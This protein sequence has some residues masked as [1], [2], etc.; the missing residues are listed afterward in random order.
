MKKWSLVLAATVLTLSAQAETTAKSNHNLKQ[1][2]WVDTYDIAAPIGTQIL[3]LQASGIKAVKV[4]NNQFLLEDDGSCSPQGTAVAIIG[5]DSSHA[6]TVTI[7]DG[8]YMFDPTISAVNSGGFQYVTFNHSIG[9]Y[10][11]QLIFS[12]GNL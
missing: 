6:S 7:Q 10:E 8:A 9:T 4:S 11:Y 12:S 5:F 3:S 2:G 1:C